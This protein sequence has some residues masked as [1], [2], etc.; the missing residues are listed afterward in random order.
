MFRAS[1]IL[2]TAVLAAT[3][4]VAQPTG[5]LRPVPPAERYVLPAETP[6]ESIVIK[7][8]EG[9]AVRHDGLRFTVGERT[10]RDR[11]S[12]RAEQLTEGDVTTALAAANRLAPDAAEGP[13]PQPQG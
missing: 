5:D 8:R 9:S 1:L 7:F 6:V 13:A 4:A 12:L 10:D 2:A 11:Q 3:G